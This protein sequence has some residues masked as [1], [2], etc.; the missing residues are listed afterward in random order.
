MNALTKGQGIQVRRLRFDRDLEREFAETAARERLLRVRITTGLLAAFLITMSIAELLLGEEASGSE[1]IGKVPAL[2]GQTLVA[3]VLPLAVF[4]L[5]FW[6][7]FYRYALTAAAGLLLLALVW[8]SMVNSLARAPETVVEPQT[9]INIALLNCMLCVFVVIALR[10]STWT[11]VMFCAGSW[12]LT[13]FSF[14]HNTTFEGLPPGSILFLIAVVFLILGAY[15]NETSERRAFLLQRMLAEERE[16]LELVLGNVLPKPIAEK[17]KQAN[18]VIAEHHP[19]ATVLFADIVDFTPFSLDR[20]AG[21]VVGFLNDLF[22]R[23]DALVEQAGLEK[24]KTVGDAYMVASGL[25]S[26][27]SDHVEAMADLALE[28]RGAASALGVSLRIGMHTGPVVAGVIGTRKYLYDLWGATVNT[29]ARMESNGVPGEIQITPEVAEVLQSGFEL[30]RRPEIEVKGVGR[31][32]PFLLR[33]RKTIEPSTW[34]NRPKASCSL[35]LLADRWHGQ[36]EE[37]DPQAHPFGRDPIEGSHEWVAEGRQPLS[38]FRLSFVGQTPRHGS[39][40]RKASINGRSRT[41]AFL[42][43]LGRC[44]AGPGHEPGDQPQSPVHHL[45]AVARRLAGGGGGAKALPR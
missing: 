38:T 29:A 8:F 40:E 21:E 41:Q 32:Q 43:H 20:P 37:R 31:V 33:R 11:S 3:N 17:L 5:C 34:L 28:L 44:S 25:P 2:I 35:L 16:R 23:F 12:G 22:S 30:E 24:I 26:P 45:S 15:F 6:R 39:R 10:A 42:L 4:I 14:V 1:F 7:P 19:A 27:R 9:A 13:T 18:Q 36:A